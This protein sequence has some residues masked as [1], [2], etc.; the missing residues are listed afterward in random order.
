MSIPEKRKVENEDP[1]EYTPEPKRTQVEAPGDENE[2]DAAEKDIVLDDY[3]AWEKHLNYIICQG[4]E[5]EINR[6]FEK[7]LSQYCNDGDKWA[8]YIEFK[9]KDKTLET[10]DRIWIES[11]F[12][13]VLPKIYSIKLWR[14]YVK[15]VEFINPITPD[16]GEKARSTVFK[17]YKFAIDTVGNDFFKSDELWGDYLRYLYNWQTVNSNESTTKEGM[18]RSVL[19]KMISYPSLKLEEN[20]N[21]FIKFEADLNINKSRKIIAD[22]TPEYLKIKS[23]NDELKKLTKNI[24]ELK[25]RRYVKRQ[26]VKWQKWIEWEKEN[27][28]KISPEDVDRRVNY[29]YNLSVQYC[30][31]IPEVWF[32]YYYYLILE[33]NDKTKSIDILEMGHSVNPTSLL[34]CNEMS[35]Y[36]ESKGDLE[37]VRKVWLELIERI[38]KSKTYSNKDEIVS[39][40]YCDL[41][42]VVNRISNI[43]EVRNIFKLA[44]KYMNI[45]WNV[46]VTYAMI[47]YY[48]NEAKIANRSFALGMQYFKREVH[49]VEKYLDFLIDTRD[50]AN[51]KKVIEISIENFKEVS[52]D[53]ALKILFNKYY[54]V[55]ERIGDSESMN[56]LIT[57]YSALFGKAK[58][59]NFIRSGLK[60]NFN[61]V[62]VVR[63]LDEYKEIAESNDSD[64][65]ITGSGSVTSVIEGLKEETRPA[66]ENKREANEENELMAKLQGFLQVLPKDA[67]IQEQIKVLSIGQLMDHFGV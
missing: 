52:D 29:V 53:R 40:L 67:Q 28:L 20:W 31:L 17:A 60:N 14:R 45:K 11:K 36:Y 37:K 5:E 32:N 25:D 10:V 63:I 44:R 33:R 3:R 39:Y 49:F 19:K 42:K 50:M 66:E 46:Y 12:A 22:C 43:K 47:E 51:F 55:E 4:N 27:H 54:E 59:S 35:R 6:S 65:E 18:I 7:F 58:I 64:V 41:L 61:G 16:N 2:Q 9:M 62:D 38:E 21:I 56:S 34:L 26:L 57:R 15:Y 13:K 1:D 30:R 48:N 24:T 23:I 8:D